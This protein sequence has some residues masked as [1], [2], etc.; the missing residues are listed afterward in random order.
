MEAENSALKAA[1]LA[2]GCAPADGSGRFRILLVDDHAESVE[3]LARLLEMYGHDVRTTANADEA[4][5]CARE[6]RCDVLLSDLDMP[7]TNGCDLL[8]CI[9]E[10]Y[11]RE[12]HPIKAI[13]IS[14]HT[15]GRFAKLAEAAGYERVLVKPVRFDDVL[16]AVGIVPRA[17]VG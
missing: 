2:D 3:P 7:V 8:R 9:R 4:L 17:A 10:I 15:S 6:W 5:C 11:P 13:A 16:E 14:A 12:T 1:S